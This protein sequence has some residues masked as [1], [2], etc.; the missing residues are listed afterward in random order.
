MLE[1]VSLSTFLATYVKRT[2]IQPEDYDEDIL[3]DFANDAVQKL[4]SDNTSEHIVAL[5]PVSN[6][7]A[8]KPK[9][10][11]KV[12]EMAFKNESY[13]HKRV[14]YHD[15]I[16]YHTDK[17]FSGHNI[18]VS[19]ECQ[20]CHEPTP[21]CSCKNDCIV[22]RADDDWL[23]ANI[24][25]YYWS[26]PFY[27]GTYGINKMGGVSCFYHP[28]FSLM[29]P[30]KH[31]FHAA[32]FHVKGCRNLDKRLLGD[33]PIEYKYDPKTRSFR[34][35]AEEGM[36]LI[37]Y[38]AIPRDDEGYPLAPNDTDAFDAIFWDVRAK[39]LYR[40]IDRKPKVLPLV[41]DAE[42]KAIFYLERAKDKID[43]IK[44][45]EWYDIIRKYQRGIRLNNTL[46]QAGR[47]LNDKYDIGVRH[48]RNG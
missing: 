2:N 27:E 8:K 36:I 15:E 38:L 5:L 10:C 21:Q 12:I 42:N 28:E 34:T 31:K 29:R 23:D 24:E 9:D 40:D 6:Y 3:L 45:A 25:R 33:W 7:N 43:A 44:P 19:T 26:V 4:I 16:V 41:Q 48:R 20:K 30:A 46:S 37:S 17:H 22:I 11:R 39:M 35:N 32:D 1:L 18:H 14:M 47:V 13:R